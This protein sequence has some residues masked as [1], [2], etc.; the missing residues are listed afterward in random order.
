[1]DETLRIRLRRRSKG[2][3]AEP[4]RATASTPN[5]TGG[6]AQHFVDGL[7]IPREWWTLFQ[8][9]P[10]NTLIERAL[11]NNHDLKAAQAALNAARENVLAHRGVF[12]PS[13]SESFAASRQRQ[14]DV[15]APAPNANV[16]Q[17]NLFTPQVSVSYTPDV[18]GLNRRTS[19]SSK[20]QEQAVGM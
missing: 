8:S 17:Y 3:T 16:F 7:D 5:V 19:E 20:A 1:L 15:L 9:K 13:I 6:D 2:H 18:F 11:A 12:F 10:L 14:S 4:L